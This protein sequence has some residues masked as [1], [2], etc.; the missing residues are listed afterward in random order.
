MRNQVAL[1][2]QFER[3]TVQLRIARYYLLEDGGRE[4]MID[5]REILNAMGRGI[6]EI[7]DLEID[8][9]LGWRPGNAM[10]VA[11]GRVA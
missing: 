3:L 7:I 10:C 5:A 2:E 4:R 9:T 6:G 8:P 11:P 1:A